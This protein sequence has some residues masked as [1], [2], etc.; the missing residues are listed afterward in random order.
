[1]T[2][3]NPT[4]STKPTTRSTDKPCRCGEPCRRCGGCK[5]QHRTKENRRH[6]GCTGFLPG[7]G[8]T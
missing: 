4:N 1:M 8:S 5:A 7:G 6:L 3:T 2:P